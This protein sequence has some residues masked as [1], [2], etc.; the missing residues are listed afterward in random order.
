MRLNKKKKSF[1][2]GF[3]INLALIIGAVIILFPVFWMLSTS[4]KKS[5]MELAFPPQFIPKTFEFKNYAEVWSSLPFGTFITN[6]LIIALLSTIGQVF[7]GALAGYAFAR[8]NFRGKNI[9]FWIC[10]STMLLPEVV[11]LVPQFII[12]TKLK[13]I[14]TFLPLIV[15][16]W[17][18]GRA[19]YIFLARQYF[20][21]IP[22]EI[23]DASKI[24]GASNF[25]IF[26]NIMLPLAKPVLAA[27]AVVRFVTDWNDFLAPLLYLSSIENKTLSVGMYLFLTRYGGNWN[28]LMAASTIMI[29]PTLIF[30]LIAQKYY[31]KGIVMTG[32]KV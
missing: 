7:T 3:F 11:L 1:I 26:F 13:W 5:G 10:I 30:F 9:W 29:V 32:L 17:L 2:K 19:F 31:L 16:S 25:R 8:I 15:P 21:S 22:Q 28:L 14:D 20:L 27:M 6:S 4:L 23:I 24:D 18:G 12:F